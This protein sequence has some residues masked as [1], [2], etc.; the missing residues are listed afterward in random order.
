VPYP[1]N[2]LAYLSPT[3]YAAELMHS[4]MG[5]LELSTPRIA[6]N[7]AVLLGVCAVILFVAVKKTRWRDV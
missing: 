4:T 2:Y 5:Y 1:L 6:L 3:T 7:W